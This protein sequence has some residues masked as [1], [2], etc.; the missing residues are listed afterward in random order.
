MPA[1][2]YLQGQGLNKPEDIFVVGTDIYI[3][4][5]GNKRIVVYNIKTGAMTSFGEDILRTPRGIFVTE[6]GEVYVADYGNSEV[7]RFNAAHELVWTFSK[8]D[9]YLFSE[10]TQYR[11]LNVSVS[12]SG[13]LYVVSEGAFEGLLQFETEGNCEFLGFFG[14]NPRDISVF[15]RMQE[16]ILSTTQM[17]RVLTRKPRAI[18]N[19]DIANDLVYTVT[20]TP[21]SKGFGP[22]S[23]TNN[24]LRR[25]NMAGENILYSGATRMTDEETFSDIAV[26]KYGCI[27]ALSQVGIISEYDPNGEL[28]FSFGGTAVS[29]ERNGLF[30]APVAIDIDDNDFVYVL[31][32]E[33]SLIQVF[34]PTEFAKTTHDAIVA[35]EAGEFSES[36]DIWQDLLRLN[37]MSKL[38]HN[39]LGKSLYSL[40]DYEGSLVEFAYTYNRVEYSKAFW[41]V[42]NAWIQSNITWIVSVAFILIALWMVLKFINKKTGVFTKFFAR[43]KRNKPKNKLWSDIKYIGTMFRHPIDSLYDLKVG[44]HGSVLSASIVYLIAYAVFLVNLLLRAFLFRGIDN[45]KYLTV[46]YLLAMFLLPC[47]LFVVVNYMISSINEGEGSFKNVYVCTAYAFSPMILLLPFVVLLTYV[48]TFNEAFLVTFSTTIIF[49]W[50]ALYFVLMVLEVHRFSFW[51]MVK[52]LLLTIFAIIIAIVGFLIIYLMAKQVIA[53]GGDVFREVIYRGA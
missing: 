23:A 2:V 48:C 28:V 5:T 34:Y 25:L 44:K 8:P 12:S 18:T 15:E 30:T 45:L 14:A 26:N 9:S 37:G 10:Q 31:D 13:T 32:K 6:D 49:A 27:F 7:Y 33:R 36:L 51:N 42:R 38:A 40:G 50:T 21:F 52:N 46:N 24:S 47:A 19:I 35:F 39:G 53:F 43:F 22:D 3:A 16:L 20:M 17:E 4:D 29:S 1:A 11:P 41:E